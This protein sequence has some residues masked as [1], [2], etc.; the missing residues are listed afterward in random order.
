MGDF[1]L[2]VRTQSHVPMSSPFPFSLV[3]VDFLRVSILDAPVPGRGSVFSESPHE[4]HGLLDIYQ[5]ALHRLFL[6]CVRFFFYRLLY[7]LWFYGKIYTFWFMCHVLHKTVY[8][9]C[10]FLDRVVGEEVRLGSL[11]GGGGGELF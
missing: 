6:A 10:W 3:G 2:F 8:H 9:I 7:L 5:H 1:L 4:G 11:T